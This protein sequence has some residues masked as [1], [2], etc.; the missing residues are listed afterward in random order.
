V[1]LS[2]S[3]KLPRS[4]KIFRDRFADGTLVYGKTRLPTLL[5]ELGS[6]EITSVL[7]EG[8]GDIL[9]QAL[10]EQLIDQVQI[11]LAPVFTGGPT[12]AFARSGAGSTQ[13]APRLADIQYEKIGEDICISSSLIYA[14]A[15]AE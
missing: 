2:T 9:G 1:V 7:I 3:G 12:V 8:G 15:L 13:E 4:A 14:Q 11:Y 5:R 10:D 6:R